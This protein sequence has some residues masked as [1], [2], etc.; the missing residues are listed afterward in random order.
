VGE[1][2]V[3]IT[4]ASSG[5][6]RAAALRFA[7]EGARVV[8]AARSGQALA[9]LAADCDARARE[10]ETERLSLARGS[11]N[12]VVTRQRSWTRRLSRIR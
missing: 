12:A 10:N 5:I 1:A 6:G 4:G 8:L 9:D 3:V 7:R 11:R 2:V